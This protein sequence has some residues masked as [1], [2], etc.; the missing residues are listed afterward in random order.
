M[1][2]W[3]FASNNRVAI[4]FQF[5]PWTVGSTL[6]GELFTVTV[7]KISVKLTIDRETAKCCNRSFNKR[8]I[9]E[10][11]ANQKLIHKIFNVIY[12]EYKHFFTLL[13]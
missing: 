11:L 13:N 10:G 4:R 5:F 3:K 1:Q 9:V 6:I 12:F 2:G 7:K 8:K